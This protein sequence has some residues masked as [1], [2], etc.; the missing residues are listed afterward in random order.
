M[1]SLVLDRKVENRFWLRILLT[2]LSGDRDLTPIPTETKQPLKRTP[3]TFYS[4][5]RAIF[6]LIFLFSCCMAIQWILVFNQNI[7]D[8][9][10]KRMWMSAIVILTCKCITQCI[11]PT[12]YL[13]NSASLIWLQLDCIATE[14]NCSPSFLLILIAA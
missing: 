8:C 10:N 13:H 1:P 6:L 9:W 4:I 5:S 14:N 3:T 2:E 11:T 12:I 7:N